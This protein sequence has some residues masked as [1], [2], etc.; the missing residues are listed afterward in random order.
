MVRSIVM[1]NFSQLSSYIVVP[2][3]TVRF[4]MITSYYRNREDGIGSI[5]RMI[6]GAY[7]IKHQ[8]PGLWKFVF[9][10]GIMLI[11]FYIVFDHTIVHFILRPSFS[12]VRGLF[13]TS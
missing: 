9:D 2:D 6:I 8:I 7:F 3:S 4:N 13:F 10:H 12:F 11:A 5:K 1:E